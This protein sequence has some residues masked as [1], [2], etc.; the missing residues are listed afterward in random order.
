MFVNAHGMSFY[1]LCCLIKPMRSI[2]FSWFLWYNS[3][4]KEVCVMLNVWVNR[5]ENGVKVVDSPKFVFGYADLHLVETDLGSRI[6]KDTSS[7]DEIINYRSYITKWG[8]PI[9]P[10]ELSDGAKILLLMLSEE[11]R[12]QNYVYNYAFCGDNC[13]KYIEEIANMYDVNIYLARFYIPFYNGILKTGVKFMES[14]LIVHDYRSF[15]YEYCR[16]EK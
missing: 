7:I 6:V 5:P 10:K 16:L 12:E 13:D 8:V 2:D 11:A 14:G 3:S 15:L 9:S 4:I 1:D